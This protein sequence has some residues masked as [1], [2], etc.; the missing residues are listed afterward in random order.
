MNLTYIV[1]ELKNPGLKK[2][3]CSM[4]KYEVQGQA[5]LTYGCRNQKSSCLGAEVMG[6]TGNELR[7]F[8]LC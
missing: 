8:L 7:E 4:I 5:E 1:I 3:I 2:S 6:I